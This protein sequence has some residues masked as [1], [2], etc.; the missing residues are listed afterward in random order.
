MPFYGE[1]YKIFLGMKKSYSISKRLSLIFMGG[2]LL[3]ILAGSITTYI[4]EENIIQ[5]LTNA[6]LKNSVYES[7]K[8]I[9][10]TLLKAETTVEDAEYITE[11]Y[12]TNPNQLAPFNKSYV[13]ESLDK[14]HSLFEIPASH[15][16]SVCSYWL[17]LDPTYTG[18]SADDEH[19]DGFFYVRNENNTYVDF[20]VTNVLKYSEDDTEHIGWWLSIKNSK[21][22][23]WI[24][25]YYNAN[26][27]RNMISYVRPFMSTDGV[28]LGGVGMDIDLQSILN[29]IKNFDEYDDAHSL[30]F[31]SEGKIIYHPDLTYLDEEGRYIGT[32][33]TLNDLVGVNDFHSSETDAIIYRYN[34][35]RRN[36]MSISLK[37]GLIYGI[38][39]RTGEL[40]RPLRT[41]IFVPQ[42]V[43]LGAAVVLVFVVHFLV[44]RHTLPLKEL[45]DAI[46]SI[47]P[48][49]FDVEIKPKHNDEIGELAVS[50]S[51]M[52]AALKEKNKMISAMAFLDGLTG[53]KNKNAHRETVR[54]LDKEIS[55]GTAQFAVVM[56]DVNNLKIIND[57]GGHDVGD[58]MI[59]GSC[60]S[61][62]KAFAHSPVYRIG[63]DEFV[64]IVE[65]DDYENR[66]EIYDKLRKNEIEVKNV[67]YDYAVGMATYESGVD[68]CFKDVFTRADEEMYKNKKARKNHEQN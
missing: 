36:A 66:Q 52:M 68:T 26:T 31:N 58:K 17:I 8:S 39:V 34:G 50:F 37:N 46:Q 14:I 2:M 3:T 6:R 13:D 42:I 45:N 20:G 41:A 25:P 56:L 63:G 30:L 55:E 35:H 32:N 47:E 29:S 16:N 61:L 18:L 24:E 57:N 22:P 23:I 12:F 53:V 33:T 9:Q 4:I 40:R 59:I 19:G 65:G 64:A 43:Y 21:N 62:C 54:R 38:S 27:N 5:N 10:D 28:F 67:K 11:T 7:S 48:G 51:N 1:E 60:Y 15:Y 49:K 44:R